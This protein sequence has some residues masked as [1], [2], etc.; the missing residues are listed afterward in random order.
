MRNEALGQIQIILN[1]HE[2]KA[3]AAN[4]ESHIETHKPKVVHGQYERN[5]KF[6]DDIYSI[7]KRFR[8][9]IAT[10]AFEAGYA[11][12]YYENKY[13]V[14][15]EVTEDNASFKINDKMEHVQATDT[16]A[17]VLDVVA[18][19]FDIYSK[20]IVQIAETSPDGPFDYTVKQ[21]LTEIKDHQ[22]S[23]QRAIARYKV[24]ASAAG[25]LFRTNNPS[26]A[27][28]GYFENLLSAIPSRRDV[29][30]KIVTKLISVRSTCPMHGI[31]I[32]IINVYRIIVIPDPSKGLH[33]TVFLI[34][35][36]F[37][38]FSS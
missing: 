15:M 9:K 4:S 33:S 26:P 18:T 7:G 12:Y 34:F 27:G 11:Y 16:W 28:K 3:E 37:S 30:E 23:I 19:N 22:K 35:S 14:I 8:E 29:L 21:D 6:A 2:M 38:L 25:K 24:K 5:D 1:W 20:T 10:L 13:I 32:T 31:C 36:T 17:K